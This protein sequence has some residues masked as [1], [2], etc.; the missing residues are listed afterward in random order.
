MPASK[1]DHHTTF[2]L[3]DSLTS[4]WIL[5][6]ICMYSCSCLIPTKLP[7]SSRIISSSL[8][9]PASFSPGAPTINESSYL[10]INHQQCKLTRCAGG[11]VADFH[12]K[13]HYFWRYCGHLIRE[14]IRVNSCFIGCKR[15]LSI[16]FA[17]PLK[18]KESTNLK[19]IGVSC[20]SYLINNFSI[21]S[22]YSYVYV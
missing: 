14:A 21:R 20:L 15:V 6:L 3:V 19:C 2:E 7:E 8:V 4:R 22:N 17:V 13:H 5:S 16:C 18:N 9:C 10:R 11:S 1:I 12:C